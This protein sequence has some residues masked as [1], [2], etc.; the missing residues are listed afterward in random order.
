MAG[1]PVDLGTPSGRGVWVDRSSA[2]LLSDPDE[3]TGAPPVWTAGDGDLLARHEGAPPP[4][5]LP[6]PAAHDLIM[7]HVWRF[8]PEDTKHAFGNRFSQIVVRALRGIRTSEVE[9]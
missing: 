3:G 4:A 8:L 5:S 7:P 2:R 9:S 6:T 1:Y